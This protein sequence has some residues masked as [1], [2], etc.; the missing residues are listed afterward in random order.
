MTTRSRFGPSKNPKATFPSRNAVEQCKRAIPPS[1]HVVLEH[2][3]RTNANEATTPRGFGPKRIL[4][5]GILIQQQFTVLWN[6]G[7]YCR[8]WT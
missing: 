6:G 2:A 3:T 8:V 5:K 4:H 1:L 7:V